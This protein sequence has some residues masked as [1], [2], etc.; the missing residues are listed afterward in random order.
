[1]AAD[2]EAA[3]GGGLDS[4]WGAGARVNRPAAMAARNPPTPANVMTSLSL[5][6]NHTAEIGCNCALP[7]SLTSVHNRRYRAFEG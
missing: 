2:L 5:A 4:V 3:T 1:V 6:T 7:A